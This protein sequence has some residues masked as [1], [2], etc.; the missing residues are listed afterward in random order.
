MVTPNPGTGSV[1]RK[2]EDEK[3]PNCGNKRIIHVNCPKLQSISLFVFFTLHLLACCYCIY[4]IESMSSCTMCDET[5]G[6]LQEIPF[7]SVLPRASC[8]VIPL[9]FTSSGLFFHPAAEQRRRQRL[10]PA[11]SIR[12]T[13]FTCVV[14]FTP[15]TVEI[16]SLMLPY[17]VL[18]CAGCVTGAGERR[19]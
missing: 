2:Q 12:A 6:I 15:L 3:A 17:G 14:F 5:Q 19:L 18:A 4:A 9:H 8:L 1:N 7:P 16:P 13:F 10:F 11:V